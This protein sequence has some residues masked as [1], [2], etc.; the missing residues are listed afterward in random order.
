MTTKCERCDG[1]T[2]DEDGDL[3]C[4]NCGW[5]RLELLGRGWDAP[6]ELTEMMAMNETANP[7]RARAYHKRRRSFA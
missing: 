7:R 3:V 1:F 2:Y 4:V 6:E 5:R